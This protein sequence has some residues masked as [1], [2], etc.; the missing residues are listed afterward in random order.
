MAELVILAAAG[1][2]GVLVLVLAISLW[3]ALVLAFGW[4]MAV[5]EHEAPPA[6]ETGHE[7]PSVDVEPERG[8]GRNGRGGARA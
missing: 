8:G 2:L 7:A 1:G 3:A 6:R 4:L 5:W